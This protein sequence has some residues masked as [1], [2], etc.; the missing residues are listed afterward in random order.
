MKAQFLDLTPQQYHSDFSAISRSM[1]WRF[2]GRK[3]RRRAYK[4]EYIDGVRTPEK[5]L[6]VM[7]MGTLAHAGMLHPESLEQIYAIYPE[8]VLGK[9]GRKGTNAAGEFQAQAAAQ[10]RIV[11]KAGQMAVVRNMVS[12]VQAKLKNWLKLN[13]IR[14]KA[15]YWENPH[16]GLLCRCMPDWQIP[17]KDVVYAFDLK[18][19]TSA[20]PDD[21]AWKVDD[22]GYWLQD[23]HYS[24]GIEAVH[25]RPC[26]FFFV[27]VESEYPHTTAIQEISPVHLADAA[28]SR[29]KLMR[30]LKECLKSGDFSEPWENRISPIVLRPGCFDV[31]A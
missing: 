19:S 25:G 24:E 23:R 12:S 21:F 14:E 17:T 7:L 13:S 2:G 22:Y 15:I 31:A 30:E 9:N 1:L 6:D 28:E 10:G 16:T 5:P 8:Q 27:V 26:K 20:H 29:I 11:L 4:A 3:G 18:T